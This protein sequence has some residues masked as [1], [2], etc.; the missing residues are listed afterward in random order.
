MFT[1]QG[2]HDFVTVVGALE[3]VQLDALGTTWR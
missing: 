1:E 2:R 3:E